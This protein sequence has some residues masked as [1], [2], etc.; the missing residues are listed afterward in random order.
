MTRPFTH[1]HTHTEKKLPSAQE[2]DNERDIHESDS[3]TAIQLW[4]I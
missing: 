2:S 1:T 3:E 4:N